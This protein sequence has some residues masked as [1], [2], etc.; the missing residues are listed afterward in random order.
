MNNKLLIDG[1]DAYLKY[2]VFVQQYGYKNLV[3]YPAVKSIKYN[4]WPELDGIDPDLTDVQ[5]DTREFGINFNCVD[6]DKTSYLIELLSNG[7]Y[8]SFN[9]VELGKTFSLRLTDLSSLSRL[10]MLGK[11]TLNF[12]DDKPL[13]S[14]TYLAPALIPISQKGYELDGVDF[15]NY[16]IY[17]LQG[18]DESVFKSPAVKQNLLINVSNKPGAIY[19]GQN[20]VYKQKDVTLNLLLKAP[21]SVTF[22]Q[23]YEAFLYDLIQKKQIIENGKAY[24]SS[25][26][27][28][29]VDKYSEEYPCYY[30]SSA[31]NRFEIIK[32][33]GFWCEFSI[34]L[35]FFSFRVSGFE[36]IPATESGEWIVTESD[37]YAI[38]LGE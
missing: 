15:S 11:C 9:F 23:N 19:D 28:L 26:R 36:Y 1:N 37:D 12:A 6:V 32:N 29:Y 2:G 17:V 14:Y 21:D 10:K 27:S 7:S 5:L 30:S 20:V 24:M 25:R 3:Q 34:T 38:D 18:S 4:D 31:V 13:N 35:V 16:G 33:G 8:H 22:W